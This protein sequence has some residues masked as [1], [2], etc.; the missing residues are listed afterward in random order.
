MESCQDP[1]EVELTPSQWD[2]VREA[3]VGNP[4]AIIVDGITPDTD[5]ATLISASILALAIEVRQASKK[6]DERLRRDLDF[7]AIVT[8]LSKLQ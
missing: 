8:A 5:D 3:L 2:L 1:K 7:S 6:L 4:A